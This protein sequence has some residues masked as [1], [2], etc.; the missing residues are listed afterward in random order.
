MRL[1]TFLLLVVGT[2][3]LAYGGSTRKPPI[4]QEYVKPPLTA[5]EKPKTQI[6]EHE[7]HV[8]SENISETHPPTPFPHPNGT[9]PTGGEHEH[10]M[11]THS[12]DHPREPATGQNEPKG[13]S[14]TA[15]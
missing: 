11:S 10:R 1:L 14:T 9:K 13:A 12:E 15:P 8:R 2:V 6:A 7:Q 5:L 4:G 3:T